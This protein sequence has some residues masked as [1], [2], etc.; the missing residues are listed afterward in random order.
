MD[1]PIPVESHPGLIPQTKLRAAYGSRCKPGQS[2]KVRA[3]KEARGVIKSGI[4]TFMLGRWPRGCGWISKQGAELQ[5]LMEAEVEKA[6]GEVNVAAAKYIKSLCTHEMAAM[7]LL[8]WLRD[9]IEK[10]GFADVASYVTRI[11]D[12]NRAG[13]ECVKRLG[14]KPIMAE[15]GDEWKDLWKKLKAAQ[16]GEDTE[17]GSA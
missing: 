3:G 9:N 16:D 11:A 2:T 12:L 8:K 6:A 5:K 13:D 17:E 1:E 10:M 7:L 15:Q 4:T 14:L